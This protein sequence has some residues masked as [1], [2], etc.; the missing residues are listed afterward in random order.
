[1][2]YDT[3]D[4]LPPAVRH[5]LPRHAQEIYRSAFNNAWRRSTAV[6]AAQREEVTHRIA[7]AAVKRKY[8]KVGEGWVPI[9]DEG[10]A[11]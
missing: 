10:A 7:W 8:V 5:H 3:I 6:D 1:M 9:R 11:P 2:P 4:D